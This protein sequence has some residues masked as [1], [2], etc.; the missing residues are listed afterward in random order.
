MRKEGDEGNFYTGGK[1]SAWALG[2]F[3]RGGGGTSEG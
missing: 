1:T 2:N 3:S